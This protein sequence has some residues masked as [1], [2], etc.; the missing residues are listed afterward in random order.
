MSVAA[1]DVLNWT[2][3]LYYGLTPCGFLE[4]PRA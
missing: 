2:A 4:V 3:A 1:V